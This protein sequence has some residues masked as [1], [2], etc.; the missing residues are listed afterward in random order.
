LVPS[1]LL[2]T[3]LSWRRKWQFFR[4]FDLTYLP[5]YTASQW[6]SWEPQT[7]QHTNILMDLPVR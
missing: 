6:G 5:H 1:G 7:S 2:L 4:K 3:V